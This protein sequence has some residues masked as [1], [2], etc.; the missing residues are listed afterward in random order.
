M[1]PAYEQIA[2]AFDR[3]G[4]TAEQMWKLFGDPAD[5]EAMLKRLADREVRQKACGLID[6]AAKADTTALSFLK[7]I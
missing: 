2:D 1:A 7:R 5:M 3:C 6:V 4:D